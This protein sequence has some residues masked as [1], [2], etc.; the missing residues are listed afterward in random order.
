MHEVSTLFK[1]E[2]ERRVFVRP[3][4]ETVRTRDVGEGNKK[5]RTNRYANLT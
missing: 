4:E 1:G 3:N 5:R 2:V